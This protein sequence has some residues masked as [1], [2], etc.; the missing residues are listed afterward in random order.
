MFTAKAVH[1]ATLHPPE[2][3]GTS[4]GR[5][6]FCQE[7]GRPDCKSHSQCDVCLHFICVEQQRKG[8]LCPDCDT[9]L[10]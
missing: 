7:V 8:I 4:T 6:T 10:Q 9:G 5:C 1:L 2:A 3:K